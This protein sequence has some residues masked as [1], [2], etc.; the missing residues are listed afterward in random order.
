MK[1]V[2][3]TNI[4]FAHFWKISF[5]KKIL[6]NEKIELF[7]PE[8]ALEEIKFYMKEIMQ[9]TSTSKAEFNELREELALIVKFISI[10]E[11]SEFLKEA[12]KLS[13]DENDVDFLA[14]AL[15]LDCP[16]WGK[17]YHL[18]QQNKI[19]VLT[20]KELIMIL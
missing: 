17:D 8:Y 12:L 15:K 1:F 2:V 13:V 5:T 10:E 20:T 9:K 3:D 14:L 11:Y 6:L 16:I 19:K 7:S 4:L 18:K